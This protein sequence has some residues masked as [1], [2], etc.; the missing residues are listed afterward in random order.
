VKRASIGVAV[1]ALTLLTLYGTGRDNIGASGERRSTTISSSVESPA[2]NPTH[3]GVT[4]HAG[5]TLIAPLV[6]VCRGQEDPTSII[7]TVVVD[8]P[9]RG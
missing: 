8:C 2:G 7:P 6:Y 9:D 3:D 1:S 5:V 4:T